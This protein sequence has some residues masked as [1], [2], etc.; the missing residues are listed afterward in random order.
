MR[1]RWPKS[2]SRHFV[3]KKHKIMDSPLGSGT[4]P[5]PAWLH[6][7]PEF[8]YIW[9]SGNVFLWSVRSYGSW[10]SIYFWKRTCQARGEAWISV[11]MKNSE[12]WISLAC[13][14]SVSLMS[15]MGSLLV[16]LSRERVLPPSLSLRIRLGHG[17]QLR[18]ETEDLCEISLRDSEGKMGMMHVSVACSESV[19]PPRITQ[20]HQQNLKIPIT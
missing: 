11:L 19:S 3:S 12:C 8:I 7:P 9:T 17:R 13:K 5:V 18:V 14:S 10:W 15:S 4:H 16:M 20:C 2:P 1:G 6:G